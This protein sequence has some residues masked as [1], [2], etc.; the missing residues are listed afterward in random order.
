MACRGSG[1]RIPS[2]PQRQEGPDMIFVRSFL[3]FWDL[4]R[5]FGRTTER[6]EGGRL[7]SAPHSGTRYDESPRRPSSDGGCRLPATQS[8]RQ[9]PTFTFTPAGTVYGTPPTVT[10]R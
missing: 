7:P 5:G 10:L 6:S 2:A 4:A 1:V 8:A 9:S 3:P